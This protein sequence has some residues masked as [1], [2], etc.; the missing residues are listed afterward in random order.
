MSKD[1]ADERKRITVAEIAKIY[2][3]GEHLATAIAKKV[4]AVSAGKNRK[5]V[6]VEKLERFFEEAENSGKSLWELTDPRYF[7]RRKRRAKEKSEQ[8]KEI[9]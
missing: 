8:G 9:K 6:S 4:G 3:V 2:N 5:L 1:E 7:E